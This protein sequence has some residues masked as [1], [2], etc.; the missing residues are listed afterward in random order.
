[1]LASQVEIQQ[2]SLSTYDQHSTVWYVQRLST[3]DEIRA[4]IE[5]VRQRM[6]VIGYSPKQLASA[7][8]ALEEG[9]CNAIKHGHGHDPA[10]IV[11]VRFGVRSDHVLFEVEDEGPGFDP[12]QVPDPTAP[13]NLERTSGRGLLLIR[14]YTAWMRY[15]RRGNCLTFCIRLSADESTH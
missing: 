7:W 8:L 14:H 5:A 1:M 11:E 15:N 4:V 13:E 3:V 10:K 6:A 12:A 9:V 2:A